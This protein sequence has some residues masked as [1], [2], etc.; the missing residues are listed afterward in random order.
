MQAAIL[1]FLAATL[2]GILSVWAQLL[3][4]VAC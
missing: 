2:T 1:M 3:L 4:S